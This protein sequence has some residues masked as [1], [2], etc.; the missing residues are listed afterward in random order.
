MFHISKEEVVFMET[1]KKEVEWG[2]F[3]L[4][5]LCHIKLKI[6]EE[7]FGIFCFS[8]GSFLLQPVVL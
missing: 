4:I 1:E 8:M 2:D 3:A 5:R 7:G 6:A